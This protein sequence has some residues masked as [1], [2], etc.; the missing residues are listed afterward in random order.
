MPKFHWN[1]LEQ[2]LK[3]LELN[4]ETDVINQNMSITDF[5]IVDF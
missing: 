4:G 3:D 5:K 2:K 1:L